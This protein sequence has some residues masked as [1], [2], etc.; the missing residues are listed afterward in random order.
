MA[1]FVFH[2]DEKK[3]GYYLHSEYNPEFVADLKAEI[4]WSERKWVPERKLWWVD[5]LA[6]EQAK[7]VCARYGTVVVRGDE[8]EDPERKRQE[9]ERRDRVEEEARR[10]RRDNYSGRWFD[11]SRASDHDPFAVLH[12]TSDAPTEVIKAAHRALVLLHHP[13][14]GGDTSRMQQINCAF[15]QIRKQRG[16]VK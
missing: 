3:R 5:K 2:P 13:D 6:F 1:Q 15:E 4:D 10:R 7:K 14:R 11:G 12:L 16:D 8:P 9:Q